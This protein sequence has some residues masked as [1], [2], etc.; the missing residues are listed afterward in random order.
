MFGELKGRKDHYS[1]SEGLKKEWMSW[2]PRK[3]PAA[4]V[5]AGGSLCGTV[6]INMQNK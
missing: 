1:Y 2:I 3:R 6:S 5:Q 4:A